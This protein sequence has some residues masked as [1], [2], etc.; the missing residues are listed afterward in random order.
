[1]PTQIIECVPNFSEGRH[2]AKIRL[3]TAAIQ[4]VPGVELLHVDAGP[5]T[6]RTVVTFVGSPQSVAEAAFQAIAKAA[7]VID[8]S[9][10]RGAH[11]RLGATDVCPLVPIEGVTLAECAA[12]ARRLGRRVGDELGIP[13]YFYEAAA[14]TPGAPTWPT[15][16]G[17]SMR[18]WP[19]S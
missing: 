1:M 3:I 4:A 2:K 12:I 16:A 19:R 11:P 7:Q 13:V 6:N 15:F 8:M 10:H 9:K 18:A 14:T 17:A 5:D